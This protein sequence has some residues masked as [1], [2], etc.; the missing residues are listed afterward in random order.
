VVAASKLL[1]VAV[2]AFAVG[3]E[4]LAVLGSWTVTAVLGMLVGAGLLFHRVGRVPR[5]PLSEISQSALRL[6]SRLVGNQLIGIGAQIPTYLLPLVVTARL[7]ASDNAY[8]YTTWMMCGIFLLI[9]PAVS[10][11]LFAEGA[12]EPGAM[13][14]KTRATFAII[15]VLLAPCMII[16]FLAGGSVLSTFGSVYEAHGLLLMK[17]VLLAAV[18]NAILSVYITVLRVEQRLPVAAWLSLGTGVGTAIVAWLLLPALGISAVGW[19]WMAMQGGGCVFVGVDV[20]RRRLVP[21]SLPPSGLSFGTERCDSPHPCA[22]PSREA[23]PKPELTTS[24]DEP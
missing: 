23:G 21:T 7:S 6:R 17:V 13:R 10:M 20:A 15:A 2:A 18:P 5:P 24:S 14:D 22:S 8:F 9:A 16:F 12:H 3:R 4:V 1:A 19:A 11:S